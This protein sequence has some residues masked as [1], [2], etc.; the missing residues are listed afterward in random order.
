MTGEE[1]AVD[2]AGNVCGCV[3]AVDVGLGG[4]GTDLKLARCEGLLQVLVELR[5][6]FCGGQTA[7]C[8]ELLVEANTCI[9]CAAGT[10]EAKARH[11]GEEQK[12]HKPTGHFFHNELQN[13]W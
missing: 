6:F 5:A 9:S 8:F 4:A 12:D 7:T 11:G 2:T 1:C 10:R 13:K 3:E